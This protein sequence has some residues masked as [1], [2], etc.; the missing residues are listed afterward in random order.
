MGASAV[1]KKARARKFGKEEPLA[2]PSA[3]TNSPLGAG[4]GDD[5][6]PE[7]E[8][9]T[10]APGKEETKGD[11]DSGKPQRFIVFIGKSS[12]SSDSIRAGLVAYVIHRQSTLHSYERFNPTAF[13]QGAATI[14]PPQHGQ[15]DRQVKR[16][17]FPRIRGLRSDEDMLE[18]VPSFELR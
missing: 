3:A 17:R 16:L 11:A 13:C 12:S 8:S 6:H 18:T 10:D 2:K 5:S 1:R 14:D 4:D 9:H 7:D 15:R